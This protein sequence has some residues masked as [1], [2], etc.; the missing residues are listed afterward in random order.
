MKAV[1][2][3]LVALCGVTLAVHG[4]RIAPEYVDDQI[5]AV[6]LTADYSTSE[7]AGRQFNGVAFQPVGHA[8]VTSKGVE[9]QCHSYHKC[10][11]FYQLSMT[12]PAW[13]Y[14]SKNSCE[15]ADDQGQTT[16]GHCCDHSVQRLAW[17]PL[18]SQVSLKNAWTMQQLGSYPWAS[19]QT[20]G[21]QPVLRTP[22]P[23]YPGIRYPGIQA[24]VQGLYPQGGY[25]QVSYP[26]QGLYPGL[27]P[28]YPS[29]PGQQQSP[30]IP[31]LPKYPQ[32]PQ[33][34]I[35]VQQTPIQVPVQPAPVQPAP[36]Q[37]AP[38]QPLPVQPAPVQP[39]P[40]QP[41]PVQP[42][43]VTQ[44]AP[45]DQDAEIVQSGGGSQQV[46]VEDG[47]EDYSKCGVPNKKIK[48]TK[49]GEDKEALDRLNP[50]LRIKGGKNAEKNEWPWIAGIYRNNRQFCGGSLIDK[51]HIL[52]AAHCIDHMTARDIPT[53][54][55][56]LG[57][58]DIN[59]NTETVTQNVKVAQIIKHK[60]FSQQTL[61]NDVAILRLATPVTY[62]KTVRAVCM[63]ASSRRVRQGTV[64]TV[65]GWGLTSDTG[66]RPPV[67]QEITFKVWSNKDCSD[68][69]GS[70]AP[71]GITSHMLCAGQKG[72]DSCMGDSGG[73]MVTLS[74]DHY[75][76]IGI[77]SWGIACGKREFPGVYTR[78]GEMR[79]WINRAVA[80]Y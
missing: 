43:A 61:H 40:V 64:A 80:K 60:D 10:Y 21:V 7:R 20:W 1:S 57:D 74:G 3:A 36:V 39:V 56:K 72:Q 13:A 47:T 22:G 5:D 76:Q 75:E 18:A 44:P 16:Y 30:L 9:G 65:V 31:G 41:A 58:H 48:Y 24:P 34:Q 49:D 27:V 15:Y 26:P 52:T 51:T 70:M 4:K 35:P 50:E 69:Y 67:L 23:Q 54:M 53:L 59:I 79:A 42:P 6:V 14:G 73:P 66:P 28:Q 63:A 17:G 37:P 78:V 8:C 2:V 55:V 12:T 71:G 62:T 19:L 68:I 32:P 46:S 33:V 45:A 77:V 25:P 29:Y 38:V 11:P